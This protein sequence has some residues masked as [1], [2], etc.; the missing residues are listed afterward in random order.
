MFVLTLENVLLLCYTKRIKYTIQRA[1]LLPCS[2]CRDDIGKAYGFVEFIFLGVAMQKRNQQKFKIKVD[3]FIFIQVDGTE[4][5]FSAGKIVITVD[6]YTC[7]KM[8]KWA[9]NGPGRRWVK[10]IRIHRPWAIALT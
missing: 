5:I 8:V 10:S 2:V 4:R 3:K 6:K 7:L 1:R 9:V